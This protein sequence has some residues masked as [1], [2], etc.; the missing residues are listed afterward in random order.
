MRTN[1]PWGRARL[2]GCLP[3]PAIVVPQWGLC[4][5]RWWVWRTQVP[6]PWSKE[7]VP[8]GTSQWH[9]IWSFLCLEQVF[10]GNLH[11]KQQCSLTYHSPNPGTPGSC[12]GKIL[13]ADMGNGKWDLALTTVTLTGPSR[14][15]A[16][17]TPLH[18][19][20]V[21]QRAVKWLRKR[22]GDTAQPFALTTAVSGFA[23]TAFRIGRS[24]S[25]ETHWGLHT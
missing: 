7:L 22:A 12:W 16:I 6:P 18:L 10:R 8:T 21:L 17:S 14:L 19:Q 11:S 2:Q 23:G 13:Q 20:G 9:S 1:W 4:R 15:L 3:P 25:S 5:L 24:S